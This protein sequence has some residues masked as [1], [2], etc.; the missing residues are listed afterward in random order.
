MRRKKSNLERMET[1]QFYVYISPWLLGFLIFT[2]YPIV[3]S[4]VLVFTDTDI[5]GHGKFIGFNNIIKAFSKD[6]LFY[7]ALENTIYY[8]FVFVPLSLIFAFLIAL[9]LNQKLKGIGIFRTCFYIPYI[10]SGIAVT[11]LWGWLFNHDVG[12]I[13]YILSIFGIKGPNWLSDEKWAMP[14]II[15]MSLW[16]IGNSIIIT[17]AGLQDI[18]TQ[19]YESAEID[20]AN[21]F[22]IVTKITLPLITPTLFFNLIIGV[23]GAFQIFMQPYV[24]TQGGPNYATYTYVLHLYN[25]AF[26]YYE[27]GYASTLAWVLF[28]IVMILTLIINYTSKRWVYYE[29]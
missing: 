14:A 17:L 25:Y 24:L 7:K 6:P 11:M 1:T 12:L 8:A 15:I 18:P 5:T 26:R 23:I 9:L 20:G 21:R 22:V 16:S 29:N 3:Y 28:I 27:V 13:N 4:L 19:L 2:L 10:T